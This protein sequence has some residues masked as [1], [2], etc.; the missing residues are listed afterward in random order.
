MKPSA[1][2]GI[3]GGVAIL[4]GV[5]SSNALYS[6]MRRTSHLEQK[7]KEE[8]AISLE[9]QEQIDFLKKN[10]LDQKRLDQGQNNAIQQ[11]YS[12]FKEQK[13]NLRGLE[14]RLSEQDQAAAEKFGE[15]LKNIDIYRADLQE[16][17]SAWNKAFSE[18]D[19]KQNKKLA[20]LKRYFLSL[21]QGVG[22]TNKSLDQL[23]SDLESLASSSQ[24]IFTSLAN[25]PVLYRDSDAMFAKMVSPTIRISCHLEVGSGTFMYSK[26]DD[27][28]KFHNY[29]FT[30][31][32]VVAGALE[33]RPIQITA[34]SNSGDEISEFGAELV[35]V[36]EKLDL[37]LLEVNSDQY[38]NSATIAPRFRNVE[39]FDP[40]CAVGCPLGYSPFPT[41]GE[42]SSKSKVL[43]GTSYWMINAPTIFGNSGGGIYLSETGEFIGVLTRVSAYNNFINIAVPHMGIMVS[44]DDI[45]QW[46]DEK[47]LRF[48]YDS[49]VSEEEYI[50][51]RSRSSFGKP[52]T[53]SDPTSTRA[54]LR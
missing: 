17:L 18:K 28:G 8:K 41:E 15:L 48:L 50:G 36:S 30:A 5:I 14:Q 43:G 53:T 20:F 42:I 6:L 12:R 52:P 51:Q 19:E 31:L 7:I 3:I 37:A 24:E 54:V 22:T 44:K 4:Y 10:L 38:F 45:Y 35:E 46:L 49:S 27:D 21:A 9:Q 33:G 26:V 40:V 47:N 23:S 1:K 13:N 2:I 32:H 25:N 29:I 11:S 16:R 34:F 39:V